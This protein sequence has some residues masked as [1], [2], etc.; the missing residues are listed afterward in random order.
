MIRKAR[1]VTSIA[2]NVAP[3]SGLGLGLGLGRRVDVHVAGEPVGWS[4]ERRLALFEFH[5]RSPFVSASEANG[6]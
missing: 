2:A 4:F 6:L 5:Q 1:R 3:V